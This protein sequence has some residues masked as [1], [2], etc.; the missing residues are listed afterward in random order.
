MARGTYE[1]KEGEF[2]FLPS[3]EKPSILMSKNLIDPPFALGKF[4]TADPAE[5]KM[6]PVAKANA[7]FFR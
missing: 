4:K 3:P 7:E 5:A 6:S 2:H 1:Y